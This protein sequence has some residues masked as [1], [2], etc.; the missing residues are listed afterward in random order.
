MTALAE[1]PLD[2]LT[3]P[4]ADRP[5][6]PPISG[7]NELARRKGGQLALIHRHYLSELARVD[8][9][10]RRIEAGD[11]PPDDLVS[12]ILSTDMRRNLHAAGTICG[13]Q[14]QVLSMHHNIEEFSM[15]PKLEQ[16]GND[17]LNAVINQ[18][19]REHEVVHELLI[20]LER[21]ARALIERQ[22][23]ESFARAHAVFRQ[24]VQV[25]TSHF[26]Y[27]ET[28]IAEAIGFYLDGI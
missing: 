26:G 2:A 20:R 19:R 28:E 27:E 16:Q 12:I 25:V 21:D 17:A 24:L 18:L 11:A 15:F 6:M 1:M 3:L 13:H 9:V 4:E 23:A 7:A 5:R 8:T 10:L 14:C 22:D